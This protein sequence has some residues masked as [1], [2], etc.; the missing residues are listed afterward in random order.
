MCWI[1][2]VLWNNLEPFLELFENRFR[3][4]ALWNC[5]SDFLS[6]SVAFW[7]DLELFKV[8][9]RTDL[10]LFKVDLELFKDDLELF[11]TDSELFKDDLEL[12]RTDSELFKD[13]FRTIKICCFFKADL[14]FTIRTILK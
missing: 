12:F 1:N 11:R 8:E 7:T 2:L 10:E 3:E 6:D 5:F 9:F 4:N 14:E 13:E